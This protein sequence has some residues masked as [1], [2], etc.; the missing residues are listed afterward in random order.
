M[1][2][3]HIHTT[4]RIKAIATPH[5]TTKMERIAADIVKAVREDTDGLDIE[6]SIVSWIIHSGNPLALINAIAHALIKEDALTIST[7][8]YS[9]ALSTSIPAFDLKAKVCEYRHTAMNR[10]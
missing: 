7:I 4:T 3:M 1:D 9:M 5:P 8:H 10:G 6:I 2:L